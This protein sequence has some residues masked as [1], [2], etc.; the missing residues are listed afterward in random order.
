MRHL[1]LFIIFLVST[2]IYLN[3]I[4]NDYNLDDELVT[5]N[6]VFTSKGI[7]A[8]GDIFTQP[9]YKDAQG[10]SYEYR[11]VVLASFALEHSIFEENPH[12]SHAINVLLY[13][14]LCML[15]FSCLNA[16][17]GIEFRT[18]SFVACLL[19]AVHPTHT[20][21]V[22]SIKNR[23]ELLALLGALG[24]MLFALKWIDKKKTTAL[25]LSFSL[26]TLG[27]LSKLSITSFAVLIPLSIILFRS[28]SL[29]KV[30]VLSLALASPFIYLSNISELVSRLV[31]IIAIVGVSPL[32]WLIKNSHL[33]IH[34]LNQFLYALPSKIKANF[35]DFDTT[36]DTKRCKK[37]QHH[38]F[39]F[40]FLITLCI[41]F[42]SY[43]LGAVILLKLALISMLIFW[44]ISIWEWKVLMLPFIIGIGFLLV[45]QSG[46]LAVIFFDLLL[47]MLF[48]LSFLSQGSQRIFFA[49]LGLVVLAA[50]IYT[51]FYN[52]FIIYIIFSA[53]LFLPL[54]PKKI[55][56]FLLVLGLSIATIASFKSAVNKPI[57][58]DYFLLIV[59]TILILKQQKKSLF[60]V[61]PISISLIVFTFAFFP[62]Y[63]LPTHHIESISALYQVNKIAAP[64]IIEAVNRPLNFLE[65]PVT[66]MSPFA[67][68]LGTSMTI[69]GSYLKLLFAPFPLAFYY[70]YSIIQETYILTPLPLLLFAF[71]LLLSF[72]GLYFI[73]KKQ[74]ISW[75]IFVYL[76]AIISFLP[77]VN[78]LAGMMADRY[79]LIPSIG[80]SFLVAYFLLWTNRKVSG[81]KTIPTSSK[82]AISALLITFSIATIARNFDWRDRLTLFENDIKYIEK[83]GYAQN[84]LGTNLVLKANQS[85][86]TAAQNI[87]LK[88]ACEHYQKSIAIYPD[89]LNS[90]FDLGRALVK[91]NRSEEAITEFKEAI[92]LQPDFAEPYIN[93]GVILDTRDQ[94]KEA[95]EYYEKGLKINPNKLAVY[96]NL[97]YA[98]FRLHDVKS[99]INTSHKAIEIFPTAYQPYV[100]LG[101]IFY[102]NQQKDSALFYF[103]K[104]NQVNPNQ[105]D[106][107][108]ALVAL[109]AEK[110]DPK[111]QLYADQLNRLRPTQ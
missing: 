86:D 23:D 17:L 88:K 37:V 79:L 46:L 21:V 78:P 90:H 14:L 98:Y 35:A 93:I 67:I 18:L 38:I 91:L 83:S 32:F 108:S 92:R 72:Q 13:G 40:P 81:I 47:V 57:S 99:A 49:L 107:V 36:F 71:H 63:S 75:G 89:F 103:E 85:T 45:P 80:F 15:L 28:V 4:P 59:F 44:L 82:L 12:I 7:S 73:R 95:A 30:L 34:K 100:N 74:I 60:Y 1:H 20:E 70:G 50:S 24:S 10:Y 64:A 101:K 53:L 9:Y 105:P 111:T 33:N 106:I 69:L 16:L 68:K 96:A 42:L 65:T 97:S 109:Y 43:F 26:F 48:L 61:L 31:F 110:N 11:P 2:A 6:H 22:A 29:T 102:T 84:L 77:I 8:L 104:A 54:I 25:L 3:A 62:N 66:Q 51:N 52:R 56:T 94:A 41:V 76:I 87:L 58:F 39:L 5:Q 55:R 27:L 19:F